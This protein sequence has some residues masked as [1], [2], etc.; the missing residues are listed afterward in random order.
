MIRLSFYPIN[1]TKREFRPSP[2]IDALSAVLL[3]EGAIRVKHFSFG[4]PA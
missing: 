3:N 4:R 1:L 2:T